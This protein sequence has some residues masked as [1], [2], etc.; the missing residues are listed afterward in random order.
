[1]TDNSKNNRKLL[2]PQ[3]N[4]PYAEKNLVTGLPVA[5]CLEEFYPLAPG[6]IRLLHRTSRNHLSSIISQGLIYNSSALPDSD[7]YPHLH[8]NTARDIVHDMSEERFWQVM[9]KDT[10]SCGSTAFS[11]VAAIFDLPADEFYEFH[12]HPQKKYAKSPGAEMRGMISNRYL[13]GLLLIPNKGPC[14]PQYDKEE[15]FELQRQTALKPA[16]IIEPDN[17]WRPLLQKYNY[18]QKTAPIVSSSRPLF[19]PE[20]R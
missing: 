18:R 14:S 12:V 15:L 9:E 5:S 4:R 17:S 8:Y 1:M 7:L 11:D 6:S 19:F 3:T 13:T 10:F 2:N 20:R 16:L